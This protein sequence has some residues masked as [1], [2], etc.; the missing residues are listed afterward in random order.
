MRGKAWLLVIAITFKS[1]ENYNPFAPVLLEQHERED[2]GIGE[3]YLSPSFCSQLGVKDE[4]ICKPF[5]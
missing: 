2:G 4:G 5:F 1:C 3:A